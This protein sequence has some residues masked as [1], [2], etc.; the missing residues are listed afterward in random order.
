LQL[1]GAENNHQS[2]IAGKNRN[3]DL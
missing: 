2:V 3:T 1:T